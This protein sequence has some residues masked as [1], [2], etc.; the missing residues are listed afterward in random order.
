MPGVAQEGLFSRLVAADLARAQFLIDTDGFIRSWNPGAQTLLGYA[1][2]EA[3]GRELAMLYPVQEAAA[4]KP[5]DDLRQAE[6]HGQVAEDGWRLRRDATEFAADA[7]LIALRHDD[8]TLLGFGCTI[9]DITD[10]K[11]AEAALARS[12]LHLR[13]ILATVPDSMIVIDER[14][15]ILSFSAAAER[16]FGYRE[17]EVVGSNV[18]ML[19]PDRDRMRHDSYIRNYCE[20]GER[21]IIGIGR[22]VIGQ[23]RDG[24]AFPME[25]AVGEARSDGHRI[26]TG[27]IRDLTEQQQAELRMKELQAELIHVSRVSAMGTMASTL[28]HELNQPL[29]AIANYMEA[30]RDLM[31]MQDADPAML[32]EAV[33]ESASEALRA[34]G[35][36]RRLREF[37]ARGEVEKRVESLPALIDEA[38][39]LALTGARERGVRA[40]F[41]LDPAAEH[42]LVDRV[43]VQQVLVN[44]IRNAVE[45][46]EDCAIRDITI[47]TRRAEDG[48][49]AVSVADTGPGIDPAVQPRL[50]DAFNSSKQSGLGL[51]LSIC[52]TIVEA[53]GGRIGARPRNGGGT[54][55]HFTIPSAETQE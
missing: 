28:A 43:Q 35:I 49:I 54:I 7:R 11:A 52:R 22:I 21:R 8:G 5:A 2:D 20:T 44:L 36:V 9:E 19:M 17:E 27:F 37:V 12:E 29:T 4:G 51:G 26:F 41:D 18:G 40:L 39:R 50:F 47:A 10:R 24:S 6:A 38:S 46:L 14:G 42:A 15:R 16:L 3:I 34:G 48:M 13:S 30:A 31:A 23:R 25:L 1:P 55:L 53:H 32:Q 33:T 45:A